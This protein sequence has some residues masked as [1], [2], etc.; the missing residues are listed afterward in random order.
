MRF[1]RKQRRPDRPLIFVCSPYRGDMAT[2]TQN[3]RR[4][5]RLVVE[6]GGIPFAPHLLFPQFMHD[7]VPEE[8]ELALFMGIVMM[9][10]C[11]ELW[12]FGE[13][14][15]RGMA[16]EIRKA[17]ARNMLIRYFT[18]SCEEVQNDQ[19]GTD[20]EKSGN[21]LRQQPSGQDMGQQNHT[22]CRSEGTAKGYHPHG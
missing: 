19:G 12:V 2:N 8:R 18:T 11:A 7:D 13:R 17:E 14:I 20:D 1:G 21:C 6:Q 9:T 16:Q 3:A 10:K 5:C 4:Y 15:S 22:L